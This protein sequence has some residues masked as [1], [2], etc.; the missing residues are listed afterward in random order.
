MSLLLICFLNKQVRQGT[1]PQATAGYF[2][3]G[4][5]EGSVILFTA[6]PNYIILMKMIKK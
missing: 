6:I 2:M 3:K 5:T 4:A 1:K